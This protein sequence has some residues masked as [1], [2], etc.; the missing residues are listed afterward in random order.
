M[1]EQKNTVPSGEQAAFDEDVRKNFRWNF[2]VNLLYGLF[3]TTG[4][5]LIMAPTFVPDY[6]F[7][8]G[9]SNLIVGI[10]LSIGGVSRFITP[11]LIASYVEDQPLLK[12]KAVVIGVLMRSQVL[13]IALAGF[14]FSPRLNLVSFFIFFSLFNMFLGMQNV[15]YNTVMA[16]VI[17]VERRGRFIGLREFVG[18]VTA[19]LVAL[20]A[21]SLIENLE[22][23]HGYA[24]TYALAFVLTFAGLICFAL[25]RES[26]TPV[27]LKRIPLLERLR[28][29]PGQIREDRNFA[30]YCLCRAIGSLALMSNP[31]LILYAGTRMP[32]SGHQLGQLTFCYFLAQTSINLYMGRIA[33]TSGFRKVFIIS[34]SIWTVALLTLVVVPATF[35]LAVLVFLMLGAGVG[36]FNMSMSNMVL[37]FGDTA[38]VPMRLGIVNSIGEMATSFGP[39]LAGLLA[40]HVS[41]ASVFLLS[42]VCTVSTLGIMYFRVSEP[43]YHGGAS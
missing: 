4:W 13:F 43:R 39:L 40:D 5:R 33:D 38:G 16:K 36:G 9:G 31:F 8:L 21:G 27:V 2:T 25:S 1:M 17:P 11:P 32:I 42:S 7:R 15:V 18:G 28:S 37:E 34:V 41:Y 6:I 26:A 12:K 10:L 35:V 23:P 14:L 24:S 20:A 22:F 29:M 30:N 3:G 19:A